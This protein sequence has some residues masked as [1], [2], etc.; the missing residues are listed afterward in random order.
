MSRFTLN[1]SYKFR[2]DQ[3]QV[4]LDEMALKGKR[5]RFWLKVLSRLDINACVYT[6]VEQMEEKLWKQYLTVFLLSTM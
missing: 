1:G 5:R 3:I 6:A 2:R 4:V